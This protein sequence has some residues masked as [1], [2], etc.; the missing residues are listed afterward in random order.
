MRSTGRRPATF[1]L[2]LGLVACGG[3]SAPPRDGPGE[4]GSWD[5]LVET[6]GDAS[7]ERIQG[8]VRY[9]E[10]E[11]GVYVIRAGDTDYDPT[12]LPE[13]YR[14]DGLPVAADVVRQEEMVSIRMVGPLVEIVR[15]RRTGGVPSA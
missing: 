14:V 13:A 1:L 4:G 5:E 6:A 8:T 10:V 11:G 9:L 3:G 2:L 12:N 15:I 7:V